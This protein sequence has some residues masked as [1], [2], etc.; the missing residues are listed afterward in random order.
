MCGAFAVI[1]NP[2]INSVTELLKV[3][4]VETR[5]IRVP[6]SS[7]QIVHEDA[8]GRQLSDAKWWLL[9]NGDGKPN[10]KYATFN[11]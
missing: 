1:N 9:L 3:S 2:F 7:I 4:E 11:S 6:A 10:Y 8:K 5:N